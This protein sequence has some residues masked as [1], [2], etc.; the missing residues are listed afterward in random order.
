MESTDRLSKSVETGSRTPL[1]STPLVLILGCCMLFI[2]SFNLYA[3]E[4]AIRFR[5]LPPED[6]LSQTTVSS[7]LQDYRGFMWFGTEDGLNRYDGHSYKVYK[8]NQD[9]T[10]SL[11]YNYIGAIHEDRSGRLWIGTIGG[12]LNRYVRDKDE[13]VCYLANPRNPNS[14]SSNFV[15]T[16]LADRAGILWVGTENG[17]NAFDP[18]TEKFTQFFADVSKPNSLSHNRVRALCEDSSGALWIATDGGLNRFDPDSRQFVHYLSSPDAPN[19]LS[20]NSVVCVFE[21]KSGMLWLGTKNGLNKFDPAKNAFTRYMVDSDTP[22]SL[23]HKSITVIYE[24][25]KE[26]LWIGTDGGGLSSVDR[27]TDTFTHHQSSAFDLRSLNGNHIYS[28]FEDR[29]GVLWVGTAR[30]LNQYDMAAKKFFHAETDINNPGSL[31]GNTVRTI[32]EER[33]GIYWIGTHGGGLNRLDRNKN[34]YL[35][36]KH[37]P[38]NPFS[39][40]S[41]EVRVV[42]T[43]RL[44][45]LWVGTESGLN[46][47]DHKTERFIRYVNNPQDSLSLS[48]DYVRDIYEDRFGQVWIGTDDGL[49]RFQ[50]EQDNFTRF[51]HDSAAP[52]SLSDNYIYAIAEDHLGE[53]W[54]GTIYGLNRFVRENGSFVSYHADHAR[55]GA[56]NNQEILFI[57]ED[58]TGF[59]WIGT[60]GGLNKFDRVTQ[61]FTHYTESDGL[62]TDLVYDILEDDHG[63][64]WLSTVRGLSRFNPQTE[65]FR[66][67]DVTDGLQSNEFNLGAACKNK[68]GEMFFGSINGFNIFHP[69]SI[70]DNHYIPPIV[71]TDFQIFNKSVPVAKPGEANAILS[72]SITEASEIILSYKDRVISFEFAALHF[73]APAKHK[74]AYI[75]QGFEE[76]WNKVGNRGFAT[77]TNL[78]SGKYTFKVKGANSDGI[79]N[80]EGISLK[81]T[82]LPPFW[83]TWWFRVVVTASLLLFIAAI[84]QSRTRTIRASNRIL[85]KRVAERTS[86]LRIANEET[87]RR[88]RQAALIHKVGQTVSSELIKEA[89]LSEIVITI[90]DKFEYYWVML[91]LRDEKTNKLSVKS[92]AGGEKNIPP[93][94]ITIS[95]NEGLIGRAAASGKTQMSLDV[96]K[97]VHFRRVGNEKT[98]SELVVPIKSG[99]TVIGVLDVQSDKQNAFHDSDREAMESLS[100]HIA[101]ALNNAFLYEQAQREIEERQRAEKKAE[102]ATHAKSEFLANMSHEI[103]TPLNAIIGMTELTLDTELNHEQQGFLQVVQSASESLLGIIN[104]VLDI[105]KIEAGQIE[106]E[107]INFNYSDVLEEVAEILS[108]RAQEKRL[109][110]ACYVEPGL[111]H[112]VMGDPTR[113]HQVLV[114][115]TGNALKFTETGEVSIKVERLRDDGGRKGDGNE[116]GLHFS[117]ADSGIG[118]ARENVDK[119]FDKFSQEDSSTTRKFGGT[120]LGLSISKSLIELMGGELWV[121]SELG[122]GT[123]FH[124]NLVQPAGESRAAGVTFQYPD[125]NDTTILVVDDNATNR[126]ILEKTVK[127]WGFKYL[128]ASNG[129]EALSLLREHGQAVEV[130]ILDHQMPDMDGVDV[131]TVIREEP[132]YEHLK[133]IMLSSWGGL[134]PGLVADLRIAKSITKPVKQSR[135][136]DILMEVLRIHQFEEAVTKLQAQENEPLS[137]PAS[138]LLVDDVPDNLTLAHRILT[139]KGHSV[140]VVEDGEQA[141]RAATEFRYDLIFMDIQMPV[142][143]GFDATAAI[144]DW[145][146]EQELEP[147]PIVALTAHALAGYREKC[148]AH[149]MDDYMTKPVKKKALLDMVAKWVDP[150]PRVLIVDDSVDNRNLLIG[151]LRKEGTYRVVTANNGRE[152][153]GFC[154]QQA[155][156]VILMDMEMP[157]MDGYEATKII[158]GLENG[159]QIPILA[160]T[161]HQGQRE[162]KACLTAGCNAVLTK[163]IRKQKLLETLHRYLGSGDENAEMH[164]APES[165]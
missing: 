106:I 117:I 40:S 111:H 139:K 46:R 56:L 83:H 78:P 158:R 2:L 87:R 48:S 91:I 119:I 115:L 59:L 116:I 143:D 71:I 36:Y 124:F 80:E 49:N 136:F 161:A 6:G 52:K 131:A 140:C 148:L 62:P 162:R 25:S 7:I 4:Q 112:W 28:I 57:Y 54:I 17:L 74:Y 38:N 41:N 93:A 95:Y 144:R 153:V 1:P 100:T 72:K 33:D 120:G 44:G 32:Y 123:T 99:Q 39:L 101:A 76:N 29:S 27:K 138:I 15:Y 156:S 82:V 90:R 164:C 8:H 154:R 81:V 151:H 157:V 16:V 85:E 159:P 66:N 37:D 152:A 35:H 30:G 70:Q 94:D 12:G 147:T 98:K 88:A 24:D 9:D 141:L 69:D 31:S 150:R 102:A 146:K 126:F 104:D 110:L 60:A 132:E 125:S 134:S 64:L 121:E 3:G 23:S 53:L 5:R 107:Y 79:W 50:R 114:N 73:S 34:I 18:K 77:Y 58:K 26:T 45:A 43:D 19:S 130:V 118:I 84:Y 142:M 163:P 113:L 55:P 20:D 160:L 22:N 128:E 63:N 67:Y 68:A 108:I 10:T 127:A 103:R 21:D 149:R 155:L 105:S 11:S 51:V 145:E 96:S 109:E 75:M 47:F 61:K 13:F 137:A 89:L 133:L 165:T 92:T 122:E 135:L 42:L 129:R 65:T 86:E 14:L 97:E